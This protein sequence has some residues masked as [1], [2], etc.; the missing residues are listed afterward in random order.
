M[1]GATGNGDT[2]AV[3]CPLCTHVLL[4]PV[5]FTTKHE[6]KDKC[7]AR[8]KVVTTTEG[9][10]S[11]RCV[12][13]ARPSWEDLLLLLEAPEGQGCALQVSLLWG[14]KGPSRSG[15]FHG[16]GGGAPSRQALWAPAWDIWRGDDGTLR[17]RASAVLSLGQLTSP[18]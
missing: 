4:C 10:P 3:L 13:E 2:R 16:K 8:V 17:P 9:W 18:L 11:M 1:N 7:I 14:R 12:R 15:G 6:F 5:D